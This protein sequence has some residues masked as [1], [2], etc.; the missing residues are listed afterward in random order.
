MPEAASFRRLSTPYRKPKKPNTGASAG[1]F[2]TFT[3]GTLSAACAQARSNHP[4]GR[5]T[6]SRSAW[7]LRVVV[8]DGRVDSSRRARSSASESLLMYARE[9]RQ[10]LC[11]RSDFVA[12]VGKTSRPFALIRQ[13][14]LAQRGRALTPPRPPLAAVAARREL[15]RRVFPRGLPSPHDAHPLSSV[16]SFSL[17]RIPHHPTLPPLT[18]SAARR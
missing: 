2:R 14:S 16:S 5:D 18:S 12:T 17:L 11:S 4:A 8:D 15:S 3:H 1:N 9:V 6:S 10:E 13:R 7:A